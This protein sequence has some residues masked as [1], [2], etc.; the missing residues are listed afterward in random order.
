VSENSLTGGWQNASVKLP[1]S[2]K[3]AT[4]IRL[5]GISDP[6]N[7]YMQIN[8]ECLQNAPILLF[9]TSIDD[10]FTESVNPKVVVQFDDSKP[11]VLS[12]SLNLSAS[13]S[14]VPFV[15]AFATPD[16]LTQLHDTKIVKLRFINDVTGAQRDG[17]LD[18]SGFSEIFNEVIVPVCGS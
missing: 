1:D 6:E 17:Y 14:Q 3:I 13:D 4:I 10:V 18:V 2:E 12:Q 7:Y 5:V 9:A 15:T 8:V 16:L 11:V